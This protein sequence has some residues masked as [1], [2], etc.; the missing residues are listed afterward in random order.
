MCSE[1]MRSTVALNAGTDC[2][3]WGTV[4][5]VYDAG[6]ELRGDDE[7]RPRGLL[8]KAGVLSEKDIARNKPLTGVTMPEVTD[9]FSGRRRASDAA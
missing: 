1:R 7:P 8:P 9:F 5:G 2:P 6:G 4:K 3:G